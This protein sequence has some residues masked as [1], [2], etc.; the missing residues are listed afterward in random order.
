MSLI[1]Q[2]V[3]DNTT[4]KEKDV[5]IVKYLFTLHSL[6]IRSLNSKR[7]YVPTSMKIEAARLKATSADCC[8]IYRNLRELKL[9]TQSRKGYVIMKHSY[10]YKVNCDHIEKIVLPRKTLTKP[11]DEMLS[12]ELVLF[13]D[14]SKDE[15][16]YLEVLKKITFEPAFI[17]NFLENAEREKGVYREVRESGDT[18]Y[19]NIGICILAFSSSYVPEIWSMDSFRDHYS[20]TKILEGDIRLKRPDKDSR[21]Y[22]N[23]T[24]LPKK[25]R[26]FLRLNGQPLFEIDIRNSQPLFA[27]LLFRRYSEKTYGVIKSDVIDYQQCCEKGIFYDLFMDLNNIR[28]ENRS[29]FKKDFFAKVFYSKELVKEHPLKQQFKSRFP[30]CHEAIFQLKGGHF[31]AKEY[32]DFPVWM[33]RIE[34]S[35]IVEANFELIRNGIDCFNI[36]DSIYVSSDDHAAIAIEMLDNKFKDLGLNVNLQARPINK[37]FAPLV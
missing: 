12:S 27:S 4:Y 37:R 17:E 30:T 22:T 26:P 1:T 35:I 3:N 7:E 29:M 16:A 36:F 14:I 5:W 32:R 24:N 6:I 15:T 33:Q 28:A 25:F 34:A 11:V 21:I 9:I 13:S 20:V 31:Y 10:S 23:F 8:M 19:S 18:G 2:H